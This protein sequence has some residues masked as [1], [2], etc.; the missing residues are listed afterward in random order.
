M[1]GRRLRALAWVACAGQDNTNSECIVGDV[2]NL[3][4]GNETDHDGPYN[5]VEMGC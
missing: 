3:L 4:A 5:G 1:P 2:P